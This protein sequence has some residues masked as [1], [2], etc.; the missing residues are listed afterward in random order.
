MKHCIKGMIIKES[1]EIIRDPSYILIAFVLP[2]ILLFLFGYGLSLDTNVV[3]IAI[4]AEEQ[5]DPRIQS[6]VQSFL[7]TRFFQVKAVTY[8]KRTVEPLLMAGK[9]KGIVVIP[10]YFIDKNMQGMEVAPIQVITDGTEPNTAKFVANYAYGV[11]KHWIAL[12]GLYNAQDVNPLIK[13][14]T[15]TWYNEELK[16]SYFLVPSSIAVILTIIGTLLTA[17]VVAREWE[18]GTMEAMMATPVSIYDILLGKFIPYFILGICSMLV[19]TLVALYIFHV[20]MRGSFLALSFTSSLYLCAALGLGLLIS[21]ITRNQF[22]AAQVALITTYLPA[23]LL[24]G[25]IFEIHS[26]PLAIRIITYFIP[27]RY[28][29]ASLRTIFLAGNLWEVLLPNII[30]ITIIAVFFLGLTVLST[31]KRLD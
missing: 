10:N 2:M 13:I 16:S 4:V 19:C 30:G 3:D 6:L 20:P 8:D 17:L 14:E 27:A 15:R 24:S 26:M 22:V 23:F 18:H 7:H 28:F 21:T 9:V 11:W 31:K 29:V 25:F 5:A 12:S 1:L